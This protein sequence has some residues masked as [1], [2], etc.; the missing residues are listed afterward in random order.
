MKDW[1]GMA[2][3]GRSLAEGDGIRVFEGVSAPR[4]CVLERLGPSLMSSLKCEAAWDG[5]PGAGVI[6]E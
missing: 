3:W 6:G 5:T 2:L 4:L 1:L